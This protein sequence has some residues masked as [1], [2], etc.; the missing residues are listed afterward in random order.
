MK[1]TD[2]F[3]LALLVA[4]AQAQGC[5]TRLNPPWVKN[6]NAPSPTSDSLAKRIGITEYQIYTPSFSIYGH[7]LCVKTTWPNLLYF[8]DETSDRYFLPVFLNGW[9]CVSYNSESPNIIEVLHECR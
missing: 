9:H 1:F 7:K 4:S 6:E 8:T 5:S 2:I 3:A